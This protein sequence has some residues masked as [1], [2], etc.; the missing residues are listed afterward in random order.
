MLT[1]PRSTGKLASIRF[2][3]ALVSSMSSAYTFSR[4]WQ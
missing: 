4:H 2:K 3:C 1:L